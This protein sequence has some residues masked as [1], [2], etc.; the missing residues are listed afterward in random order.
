MAICVYEI[1]EIHL[2]TD[3]PIKRSSQEV[4]QCFIIIIFPFT[5]H[6]APVPGRLQ[7]ELSGHRPLL[8]RR[9]FWKFLS[10]RFFSENSG[11]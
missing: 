3:P 2:T 10:H 8:Q 4:V 1:P 6:F 11:R 9:R 7:K 5:L